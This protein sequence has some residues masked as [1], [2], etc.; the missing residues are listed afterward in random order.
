MPCAGNSDELCGGNQ[1]LDLY[2]ATQTSTT[3]WSYMGCFTDNTSSRTLKNYIVVP[4]GQG[5]TTRESCQSACQALGYTVSGVEY[6]NE[7]C[8]FPLPH[9][10]SSR[11]V[12]T[13]YPTP[14]SA[15]TQSSKAANPHQMEPRAATWAALVTRPRS[16][17]A[18][19]ASTSSSRRRG[20]R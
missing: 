20:C 19:F 7:C 18:T 16:A 1:R 6:A 5:A 13:T 12:L 2:Q 9:F 17:A 14:Q 3:S 8:K 11:T 4:G 10:P 15:T